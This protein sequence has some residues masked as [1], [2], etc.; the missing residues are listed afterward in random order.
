MAALYSNLSLLKCANAVFDVV[1][2]KFFPKINLLV[3]DFWIARN[4]DCSLECNLFGSTKHPYLP[5][6]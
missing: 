3:L 6:L 4:E 2:N 5:P 1:L